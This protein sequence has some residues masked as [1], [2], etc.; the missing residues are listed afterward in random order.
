[1][2]GWGIKVQHMGD[3]TESGGAHVWQ[4]ADTQ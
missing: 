1:M 2:V 3:M 4:D